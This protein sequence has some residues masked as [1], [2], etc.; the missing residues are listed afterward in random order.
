M[1]RFVKRY[2]GLRAATAIGKTSSSAT[3]NCLSEYEQRG[4]L[5]LSRT[6]RCTRQPT[7]IAVSQIVEQLPREAAGELKR[8]A[9]DHSL[10]LFAQRRCLLI[11][12]EVRHDLRPDEGGI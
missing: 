8:S 5:V 3:E 2:L 10:R 6:R 4:M 9:P 1:L 7:R 11:D 12:R